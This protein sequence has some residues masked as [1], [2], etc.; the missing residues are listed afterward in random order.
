[1]RS[2][3]PEA[4]TQGSISDVGTSAL[5][6]V[7]EVDPINSTPNTSAQGPTVNPIQIEP[8]QDDLETT[9]VQALGPTSTGPSLRREDIDWID[10]PWEGDIF[11]DDEDMKD[12]CWS[13]LTLNQAL[14]LSNY[15]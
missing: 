4:G 3:E 15:S 5:L 1:M 7:I 2:S 10:T 11:E 14:T 13:I 6:P 9:G 12:V 8:P